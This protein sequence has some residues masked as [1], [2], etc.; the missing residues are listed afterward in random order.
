MTET[1][2][3]SVTICKIIHRKRTTYIVF[4]IKTAFLKV[5]ALF[6]GIINI[7]KFSYPRLTLNN[8][9]KVKSEHIR[10]FTAHV[11]HLLAYHCKLLGPIL[12]QL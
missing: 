11:T 12:S 3:A 6:T 7:L 9:H 4:K 8:D 2:D 10:R 5:G 1:N